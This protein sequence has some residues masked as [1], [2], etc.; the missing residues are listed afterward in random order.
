MHMNEMEDVKLFEK[1]I[2]QYNYFELRQIED[3]LILDKLWNHGEK[4][5]LLKKVIQSE[6]TSK[7]S[8]FLA[9]TILF[10]FNDIMDKELHENL[11]NVY[12]YA[13]RHT[14]EKF[15][16][17]MQLNA[18]L[19][20]FLFEE[21]DLGTLGMQYVSFGDLA[22][23]SLIKLLNDSDDEI[24]YEGSEEATLGN[25]YQYR[26]K[27]FAAFYISKIKDIPITF[28]QDFEKRDAEIKRLQEILDNE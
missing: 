15:D 16:N 26:V 4:R 12:A 8:K 2:L 19:W 14:S 5:D 25:D 10:E 3:T 20:G 21:D 22:M 28:Y 9:A 27:D 11:S 7:K 17:D 6:M 1:K 18:N 24:Y 23:P 13:L